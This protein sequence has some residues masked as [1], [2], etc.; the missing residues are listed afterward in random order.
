MSKGFFKSLSELSGKA[1]KVLS[2]EG[3]ELIDA[4]S[5]KFTKGGQNK[6]GNDNVSNDI[7]EPTSKVDIV[8]NIEEEPNEKIW[9]G[10]S[11]D[12]IKERL[13]G[14]NFKKTT[15]AKVLAIAVAVLSGISLVFGPKPDKQP[16][17]TEIAEEEKTT[18]NTENVTKFKVGITTK[19]LIIEEQTSDW[20]GINKETKTTIYPA[21]TETVFYLDENG[22]TSSINLI[23]DQGVVDINLKYEK[24]LGAEFYGKAVIREDLGEGALLRDSEGNPILDDNEKTIRIAPGIMCA[25]LPETVKGNMMPIIT[26]GGEYQGYVSTANLTGMT[27]TYSISEAQP[28]QY[29]IIKAKGTINA[30]ST[31]AANSHN[32]I[33]IAYKIDGTDGINYYFAQQTEANSDL[34]QLPDGTYITKKEGAFVDMYTITEDGLEFSDKKAEKEYLKD[35]PQTTELKL[36]VNAYVIG[37]TNMHGEINSGLFTEGTFISTG[38]FVIKLGDGTTKVITK[39]GMFD[40][41]KSEEEQLQVEYSKTAELVAEG[42][43]VPVT[44]KGT[45]KVVKLYPTGTIIDIQPMTNDVPS[46]YVPFY[47]EEEGKLLYVSDKYVDRSKLRYAQQNFLPGEEFFIITPKGGEVN[48]R[49]TP[50][51]TEDR[52]VNINNA[53][54]TLIP[55]EFTIVIQDPY[56]PDFYKEVD[57]RIPGINYI[58]SEVTKPVYG[59]LDGK[60][61]EIKADN[62]ISKAQQFRSENKA[63]VVSIDFRVPEIQEIAEINFVE[64]E[65]G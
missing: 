56:H 31:Q 24:D 1:N 32:D 41:S 34:Y 28:D 62:K 53:K 20:L 52:G 10:V 12:N 18:N 23:T 44:D 19:D 35:N 55:G 51:V 3:P 13:Q 59:L 65:K 60:I 25:T 47:D 46:G 33:N 54:D 50:S 42:D 45:I 36:D 49:T 5:K 58:S 2:M 15:L 9:R 57:S 61:S 8:D 4:I 26:E 38:S 16:E 21:F 7:T 14:I 17:N 63:G 11:S 39:D 29:R 48:I 37:R 27:N 30:R 40:L 43:Y 6:D 64:E 22:N